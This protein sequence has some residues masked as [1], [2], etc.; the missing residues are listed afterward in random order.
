MHVLITGA[1]R[2]IGQAI[3]TV[4][5]DHFRADLQL[6]LCARNKADLE[7]VRSRLEEA[8]SCQVFAQACDVTMSDDIDAFAATAQTKFGPVDVLVNNA[9]IGRFE[10][11]DKMSTED[12]DNVLAINLRG[13]F[14][15]TR[16]VLPNMMQ[17]QRGTIVTISS[18]AG[19]NGLEN[20]AAYCA[21]K[22]GV[23]GLMQSLFLEVRDNN[24]RVLTIFPG[25]VDTDF[26][27]PLGGLSASMKQPLEAEDVAH[28]VYGAISLPGRATISELDLRPTNPKG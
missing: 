6:S 9:G 25:T 2:G 20:G 13:V 11:V 7:A 27:A 3:A 15:M 24:I 12:F 4:F 26:F 17:R 8:T 23:R 16:A 21:S 1:S 10:S 28:A 14:L 5:A 19:R 18:L 22:F